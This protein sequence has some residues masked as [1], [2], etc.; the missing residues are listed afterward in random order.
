MAVIGLAYLVWEER[1]LARPAL[2]TARALT[3]I[4]VDRY[5]LIPGTFLHS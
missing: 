3:G 2:P 1:L 5:M 4:Q